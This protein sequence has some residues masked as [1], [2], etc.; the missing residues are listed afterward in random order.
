[1]STTPRKTAAKT[2]EAPK[3]DGLPAPGAKAPEAE[4]KSDSKLLAEAR[5]AA[6][7]RVLDE[8]RDEFNQY[9]TEEAAA[10]NV[11]WKRRPTEQEKREAKLRE[12]LAA[13]PDLLSRVLPQE[14]DADRTA[15]LSGEKV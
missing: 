4:V 1:M 9:M 5:T 13:D 7:G 12:L 3:V 6:I 11:T 2:A 14:G 15:D 8:D 10:R